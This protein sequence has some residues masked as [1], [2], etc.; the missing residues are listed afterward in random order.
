MQNR[1]ASANP[2]KTKF[3]FKGGVSIKG[4]LPMMLSQLPIVTEGSILGNTIC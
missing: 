4:V 2:K 1:K 3:S